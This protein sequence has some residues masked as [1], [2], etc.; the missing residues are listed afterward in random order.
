MQ[1]NNTRHDSYLM[2]VIC[3]HKRVAGLFNFNGCKIAMGHHS[4]VARILKI[5]LI[6]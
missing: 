3:N 4:S 6:I 1:L 2:V 5:H